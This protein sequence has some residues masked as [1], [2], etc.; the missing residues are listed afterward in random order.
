MY[1]PV[2]GFALVDGLFSMVIVGVLCAMKFR[3]IYAAFGAVLLWP[4]LLL[5]GLVCFAVLG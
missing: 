2:V 3:S 4:G 5:L 1:R